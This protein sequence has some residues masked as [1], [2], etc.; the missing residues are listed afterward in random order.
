MSYLL[1]TKI[2]VF[3]HIHTHIYLLALARA[4]KSSVNET[5]VFENKRKSPLTNGKTLIFKALS[6]LK[7]ELM[8]EIENKTN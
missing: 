6:R 2:K 4:G 5:E 8:V 1:Y 7:K 3:S